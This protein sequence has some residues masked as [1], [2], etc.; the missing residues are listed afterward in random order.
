VAH[1][2]TS[3][4]PP[5]QLLPPTQQ[6][7]LLPLFSSFR[8]VPLSFSSIPF[9]PADARLIP[10]LSDGSSTGT[11]LLYLAG[12]LVRCSTI[13]LEL[14]LFPSFRVLH[15]LCADSSFLSVSTVEMDISTASSLASS[16]ETASWNLQLTTSIESRDRTYFGSCQ[17]DRRMFLR[18]ATLNSSSFRGSF[19]DSLPTPT[20]ALL[21]A[22]RALW[23][24]MT[25]SVSHDHRSVEK[26][27]S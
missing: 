21:A 23:I 1:R 13:R 15:V 8:L 20:T 27:E 26:I 3:S 24:L 4:G 19:A 25:W 10:P 12:K 17:S 6:V 9:A 11:T 16:L 22:G 5:F 7:S 2:S 18:D 14:I